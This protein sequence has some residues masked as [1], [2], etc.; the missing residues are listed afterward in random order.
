MKVLS[1]LN[2]KTESATKMTNAEILNWLDKY[3]DF[4]GDADDFEIKD[5]VVNC[6]TWIEIESDSVKEIPFQFGKCSKNFILNCKNLKVLKGLPKEVVGN[7]VLEN[8]PVSDLTGCPEKVG[9][10]VTFEKLKNITSL[11]GCPKSIG[12]DIMIRKCGIVTLRGLP[13]S[14]KKELSVL[15]ND[16]LKDCNGCPPK[17]ENFYL[18]NNNSLVSL[19]GCPKEIT[20]G[21]FYCLRNKSLNSLEGAPEKVAYNFECFGNKGKFTVNDIKEVSKVGQYMVPEIGKF[22]EQ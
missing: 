5:G 8:C 15:E 9:G 22:I 14:F 16:K 17:L 7:F 10:E 4:G 21:G 11:V 3:N 1:R 18:E 13:S 12:K 19:K 20:S 6:K 2:I